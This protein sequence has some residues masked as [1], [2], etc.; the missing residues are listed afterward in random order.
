MTKAERAKKW[1]L[2][3]PDKVKAYQNRPDVKEK[4]KASSL[5]YFH[6]NKEKYAEYVEVN[7]DKIKDYQAQ[8]REEN[9]EELNKKLISKIQSDP[10]LRI[11]TN[12]RNRISK[13]KIR[14]V[15]GKTQNILGCSFQEFRKHIENKFEPWMN[16]DNY[17]R[18]NGEFNYG[19]DLDHIVPLSS[20]KSE[21]EVVKLNHY[22]NFQPLCSKTNRNIK[23]DNI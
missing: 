1:R 15:G 21:E 4:H 3:N 18:Y 2:E 10:L 22:T 23:R 9:R 16:W 14:K 20:A 5:K 19:W 7:K 12:I 8:Y 17:G 6:K 11:K 13:L